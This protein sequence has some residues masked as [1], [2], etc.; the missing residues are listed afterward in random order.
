MK[1]NELP[2]TVETV[3]ASAPAASPEVTGADV[4]VAFVEPQR[5]VG[6]CRS[7]QRRQ[8]RDRCRPAGDY[9]DHGSRDRRSIHTS[10]QPRPRHVDNATLGAHAQA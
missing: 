6:L 4:Q 2:T 8:H 5:G 1:M 7:N 10:Y 9:L 3:S